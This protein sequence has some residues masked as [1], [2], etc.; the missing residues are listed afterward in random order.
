MY[1]YDKMTEDMNAAERHEV[2]KCPKCGAG[3]KVSF[4]EDGWSSWVCR[5]YRDAKEEFH[6][7]KRCRY[8]LLKAEN[9]TLRADLQAA[10]DRLERYEEVLRKVANE[11]LTT[12]LSYKFRDMA[13]DVLGEGGK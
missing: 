9:A 7:S 13:R 1:E 12:S 3:L 10:N 8:D 6:Q 2:T 5:S 4:R 11:M